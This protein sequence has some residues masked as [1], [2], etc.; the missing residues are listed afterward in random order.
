MY[1][2]N[3]LLPLTPFIDCGQETVNLFMSCLLD[4]TACHATGLFMELGIQ[5]YIVVLIKRSNF[6]LMVESC[7]VV[8]CINRV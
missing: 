3:V 4:F 6:V 1:V 7:F 8:A 5:L 2:V